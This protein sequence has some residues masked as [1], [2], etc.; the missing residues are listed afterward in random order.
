M[1]FNASTGLQTG[2]YNSIP[3]VPAPPRVALILAES[4]HES[5]LRLIAINDRLAATLKRLVGSRPV[6]VLFE[7][8]SEQSAAPVTEGAL[9]LAQF[10]VTLV[11]KEIER[12]RRFVDCLEEIA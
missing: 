7:E 3:Q 10:G 1:D 8:A 9:S 2:G 5:S 12:M 11:N 6:E 4:I